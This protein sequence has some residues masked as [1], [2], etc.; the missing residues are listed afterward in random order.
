MLKLVK[1]KKKTL[2]C[3]VCVVGAR[4][5]GCAACVAGTK[6]R[7]TIVAAHRLH[8]RRGTLAAEVAGR[9]QVHLEGLR[10]GTVLFKN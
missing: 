2:T 8:V 1:L 7:E 10:F 6:I 4:R 9:G 5:V 3:A